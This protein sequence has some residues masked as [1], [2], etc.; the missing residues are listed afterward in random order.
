LP[1]KVTANIKGE[2]KL[3]E[4]LECLQSDTLDEAFDKMAL[5]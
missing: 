4:A 5:S 3:Q 1:Q 2:K